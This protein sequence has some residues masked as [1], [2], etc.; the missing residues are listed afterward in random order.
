MKKSTKLGVTKLG[1][2]NL[3]SDLDITVFSAILLI[4]SPSL[5][6][7]WNSSW[8]APFAL[9]SLVRFIM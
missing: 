1:V 4:P 5:P 9:N 2:K 7:D 6:C 3:G 8:P